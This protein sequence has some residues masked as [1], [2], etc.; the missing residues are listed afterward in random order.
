MNAVGI[1][2]LSSFTRIV[3]LASNIERPLLLFEVGFKKNISGE[4]TNFRKGMPSLGHPC[5]IPYAQNYND[6]RGKTKLMLKP[7]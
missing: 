1:L 2:N 7:A 5:I 6:S 4:K 3:T